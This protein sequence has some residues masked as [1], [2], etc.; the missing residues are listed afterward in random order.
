MLNPRWFNIYG[1]VFLA[2]VVVMLALVWFQLVP[3][4]LYVPLFLVALSLYLVRITLRLLL[5]RQRRLQERESKQ[6]V[7]VTGEKKL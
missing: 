1:Y 7:D 4:T 3:Q 6:G 5:E 2:V